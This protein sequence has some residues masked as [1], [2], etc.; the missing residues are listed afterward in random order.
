M[1]FL[2]REY[3]PDH[4]KISPATYLT[5]P[6]YRR[7]YQCICA[8]LKCAPYG[9]SIILVGD[10]RIKE[11]S[12]SYKKRN[13]VTDVLSFFY[14]KAG[15]EARPHGEIFICIP[16]A[17]RQAKRYHISLTSEILRLVVHGFLHVHGY[18]HQKSRERVVMRS[19]EHASIR[20]CKKEKLS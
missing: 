15:G 5:V 19:L 4:K 10:E 18:D 3:R 17:I 8:I 20:L 7:V 1:I 13:R 16:Q 14:E 2:I 9:I 6:W 11:L 12:A